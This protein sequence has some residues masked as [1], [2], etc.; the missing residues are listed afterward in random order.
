MEMMPVGARAKRYLVCV[1]LGALLVLGIA[2]GYLWWEE[3]Q[4]WLVPRREVFEDL[5]NI[6]SRLRT[7]HM[8]YREY[9]DARHLAECLDGS[10]DFKRFE[11]CGLVITY[12]RVD[13]NRFWLIVSPKSMGGSMSEDGFVTVGMV[14]RDGIHFSRVD[15]PEILPVRTPEAVVWRKGEGRKGE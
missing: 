10:V 7:W 5:G 6:K 2:V 8:V 11:K 4:G 13:P 1:S 9:P 15:R 14:D 12:R 3:S